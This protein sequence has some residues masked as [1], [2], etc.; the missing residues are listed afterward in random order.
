MKQSNYCGIKKPRF[1]CIPS[2]PTPKECS[3]RFTKF[4]KEFQTIGAQI[5][6]SFATGVTP[7]MSAQIGYDKKD[8]P[9]VDV[10]SSPNHD[11]FD[12]AEEF[13]TVAESPQSAPSDTNRCTSTSDTN[14]VTSEGNEN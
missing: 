11:F 6:E 2:A 9:G 12:I 10:L 7:A 14:D 13:A 1:C 3:D 4:D 8:T 5:I